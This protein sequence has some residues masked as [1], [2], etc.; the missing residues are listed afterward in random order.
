[1]GDTWEYVQ[2][3]EFTEKECRK[4]FEE[5]D[6]YNEIDNVNGSQDNVIEYA[7]KFYRQGC[8]DLGY[9]DE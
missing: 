2:D 3:Q 6:I 8:V 7:F 5:S 9:L 1:M 4:N